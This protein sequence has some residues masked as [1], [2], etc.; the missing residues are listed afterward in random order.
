MMKILTINYSTTNKMFLLLFVALVSVSCKKFLTEEPVTA[1]SE[2]AAF[3]NPVNAKYAVLGVYS[4]LSGDNGFGNRLSQMYPYDTDEMICGANIN[5][6]DNN[7]RDLA[8]Y[9]ITANNAVL[10]KPFV[11]LYTGIERANICIKNIPTMEQYAN[12]SPSEQAE[13]KRLHGEAL[14]LRALFYMEL[15]K[16]WG[17]VPAS[18]EP[19]ADQATLNLPKTDRDIIYD[20]LLEDL[21]N[22]AAM[23]PWRRDA[24]VADDE[25]ITKGAVKALRARIALYRGG[26]SLRK[27][28]LMERR[29]D[30]RNFYQIARDECR[31]IMAVRNK[32]TLNPSFE[33]VFKDA[34][35]AHKLEPNGEVLLEVAMAG[36]N[37]ATDSKLGA[38]CGP[39]VNGFGNFRILVTPSYFYAFNPLDKRRNVTTAPY[40]V[41][42]TLMKVGASMVNIADGKFRRDWITPAIPIDV[43]ATWYGVNWPIIRFSDVLLMFAEAENELNDGPTAEAIAAV[44]EVRR[45]SFA[46][47]VKEIRVTNGGSGYTTVPTVTITGGGGSGAMA[48]ATVSSGRVT[49]IYVA[50]PGDGYTSSPVVTITGNGSNAVAVADISTDS[51]ADLTATQTQGKLSFLEAIQNE[52]L[53]EF[54]GEGIRKYDLIRWN[55]LH[56]KI[57][58]ARE[59]MFKMMRR[60]GKYQ[61]Y[62]TY[63]FFRTN[64]TDLVFGNSPYAPSPTSITGFTRV[65]WLQALSDVFI[66]KLAA[67]FQ[68]NRSELYAL[69]QSTIESNRVLS[70]DYGY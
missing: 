34:L 42:N 36:N 65:N 9:S 10:E 50:M 4:Q 44:N 27:S 5:I 69:P 38:W 14:T 8:R 37:S 21:K 67:D 49:N 35:L 15:I 25:R 7:S 28:K 52:R 12:G 19:S 23:V 66:N 31:D 40:S 59:E 58:E 51:D 70:Q 55:L 16:H 39:R 60:E 32:H 18:F 54:G 24:G 43:G 6:P 47:G 26:Y 33:A 64:S 45:R 11:Q 30:Y 29:A 62:P 20:R 68:P 57:L 22:A 1:V 48:T 56:T 2:K 61:N 13:L 41:N 3:S 63:L 46:K 17:D 53:L